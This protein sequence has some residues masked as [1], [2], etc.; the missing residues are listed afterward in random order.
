MAH[1][2]RRHALGQ[3][4]GE[5][6]A[7]ALIA[8]NTAAQRRQH[9]PPAIDPTVV[10]DQIAVGAVGSEQVHRPGST[11]AVPAAALCTEPLQHSAASQPILNSN[12]TTATA[13]VALRRSSTRCN[14]AG[15]AQLACTQPDRSSCSA[16]TVLAPRHT[17]CTYRTVQ[18]QRTANN[19]PHSSTTTQ[20]VS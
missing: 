9:R 19:N 6:R 7:G 11:G 15:T 8:G 1:E 12:R 2:V 13:A 14:L 10:H 16:L 17:V 20:P 4:R 5:H 3:I 18:N